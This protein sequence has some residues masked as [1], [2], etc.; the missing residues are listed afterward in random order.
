VLI[1]L[2]EVL[3]EELGIDAKPISLYGLISVQDIV[4]IED[5]EKLAICYFSLKLRR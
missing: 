4:F 5:D 3:D 2:A 1:T